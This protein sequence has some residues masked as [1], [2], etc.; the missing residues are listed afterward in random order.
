[1]RSR[2][3]RLAVLLAVAGIFSAS[4]VHAQPEGLTSWWKAEGNANDS[5]G[6]RSGTIVNGVGFAAGF[7]G[8]AFSFDGA[9]RYV[10]VGTNAYSTGAFTVAAWV[11]PTNFVD[12]YGG[13]GF[14]LS[15]G[16]DCCGWSGGGIGLHLG[17][18]T[19]GY[20]WAPDNTQIAVGGVAV[21]ANRWHHLVLVLTGTSLAIYQDGFATGSTTF[22]ATTVKPATSTLQIGRH[23]NC[24]LGACYSFHGLIDD[25]QIYGRALTAAEIQQL[26]AVSAPPG[27][28][29]MTLA[30]PATARRG[31]QTTV[32]ATVRNTTQTARTITRG[33][34]AVHEGEMGIVGPRALAVDPVL[35]VAVATLGPPPGTDCPPSVTPTVVTRDIPITV[36]VKPRTGALVSV[37]LTLLGTKGASGAPRPLVNDTCAIE[38][39]K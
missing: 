7:T 13:A 24:T 20:L 5:A 1:M 9:N 3:A 19:R 25:V 18:T 26:A 6:T 38:I 21:T 35:A 34:L 37:N 11:K 27:R 30:C 14:V 23:V 31:A 39:V 33:A 17:T 29:T 8:Q 32:T 10:D 36:P 2:T 16:R 4:A 12:A 15:D 22:P 28:F